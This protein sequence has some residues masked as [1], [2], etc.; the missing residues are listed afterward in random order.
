[1]KNTLIY[2]IIFNTNN[3][4][5]EIYANNAYQDDIFSFI[6]V[7]GIIFDNNKG[8]LIDPAEEQIRLE[9]S[10][11]ES[12]LLPVQSVLRIDIVKNKGTSKLFEANQEQKITQFPIKVK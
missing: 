3:K 10:G 11:V 7:D 6:R 12:L 2:K 5:Y 8:T 9:F 1:M 4:V